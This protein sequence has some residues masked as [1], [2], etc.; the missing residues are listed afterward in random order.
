MKRIVHVYRGF[1]FLLVFVSVPFAYKVVCVCFDIPFCTRRLHITLHVP[2]NHASMD[3]VFSVRARMHSTSRLPYHAR[4]VRMALSRLSR[5]D[6]FMS[7]LML[8]REVPLRSFVKVTDDLGFGC[9]PSLFR[10]GE[11]SSGS[12][13]RSDRTGKYCRQH[14][15]SSDN[16][17]WLALVRLVILFFYFR[18]LDGVH[19]FYVVYGPLVVCMQQA[20]KSKRHTRCPSFILLQT[21]IKFRRDTG[22][23]KVSNGNFSLTTPPVPSTPSCRLTPQE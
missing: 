1:Y 6:C 9:Q 14:G 4:C 22:K 16:C 15:R 11:S 13:P 3:C 8:L 20:T 12:S 19:C 7:N 17:S 5:A 2:H 18:L 23:Q 10:R 21:C